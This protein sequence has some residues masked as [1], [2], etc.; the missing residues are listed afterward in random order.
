[1]EQNIFLQIF[2]KD[3]ENDLALCLI[4][5]GYEVLAIRD[6]NIILLKGLQEEIVNGYYEISIVDNDY[7]DLLIVSLL[8]QNLSVFY[9][10]MDNIVAFEINE[11]FIMGDIEEL[12]H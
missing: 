9:R 12:K 3:F 7:L 4:K 8:N 2:N 5:Q 11:D 10:S 6:K 1:M